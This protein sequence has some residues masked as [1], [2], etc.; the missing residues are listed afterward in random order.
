MKITL[1][2]LRVDEI[3]SVDGIKLDERNEELADGSI[4]TIFERLGGRLEISSCHPFLVTVELAPVGFLMLREGQA[5]PSWAKPG[6]MSLHN[7]RISRQIQGRGIGTAALAL[8]AVWIAVHRPGSS[9]LNLSVNEENS[10]A[11]RFY[12]RCG[13]ETSGH[14]VGRLGMELVLS[15]DVS[16]LLKKYLADSG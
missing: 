13:F 2:L 7:F 14:F 3:A 12:R 10:S 4:T 16:Q 6:E 11:L 15:C 9:S 8:A 1:K 5:L